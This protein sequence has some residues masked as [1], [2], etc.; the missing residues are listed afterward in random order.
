MVGRSIDARRRCYLVALAWA[1]LTCAASP[2]SALAQAERPRVGVAFGGGS[3]RG[4][5][6]VGI[7]AWF[8]EHHI[9]I[10]LS[11]G[12]SMGGPDRRR[13]RGGHVGRRAASADRDHRLGRDVRELLL[14]VQEHPA[15]GRRAQ[16]S[17][18]GSSS[19]CAAAW[20]R[21]RRSTTASRWTCCWRASPAATIA[22]N[23]STSCR[24]RSAPSPSICGRPSASSSTADRSRWRCGP[25]CR[26]R[27]SFRRS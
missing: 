5:A 27:A 18:R 26:C 20:C 3:A 1:I 17:R 2:P 24:R 11:A 19:G 4:I 9:P 13:V 23:T 12:T 8:E 25:R 14:P 6:H 16:L 21:R 22:S 10:D 15:Q 7:I